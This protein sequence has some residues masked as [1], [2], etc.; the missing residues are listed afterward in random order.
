[1]P[2]ARRRD[3][4]DAAGSHAS[5][6]GTVHRA[7]GAGPHLAGPSRT[8]RRWADG[9]ATYDGRAMADLAGASSPS[10]IRDVAAHAGVSPATV[11]NYFHHPE[12]M[13][14]ATRERIRSA[15]ETLDFAPND[16]ARSLRRG[17]NPV[18]GYIS[19]ELASAR[20]PAILNAISDSL[21]AVD[22]QL[23]SAVDGATRR[24]S[25]PTSSCSSANGSPA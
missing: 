8:N 12:R 2:A 24:G 25:V 14:A 18:V 9:G 13:S 6:C 15:V 16:A 4:R 3:R 22:M 17:R 19:F 11:S 20:T 5:G 23:L 7:A 21:A 1:M 10:T